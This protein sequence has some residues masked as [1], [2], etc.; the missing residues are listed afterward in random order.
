MAYCHS[1]QAPDATRPS[2]GVGYLQ[3]CARAYVHGAF[4][5]IVGKVLD[6]LD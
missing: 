5:V 1:R 4:F 6:V 2:L 3:L